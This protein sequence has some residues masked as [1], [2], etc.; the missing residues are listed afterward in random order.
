RNNVDDMFDDLKKDLHKRMDT[1]ARPREEKKPLEMARPACAETKTRIYSFA[2]L[3]DF[4]RFAAQNGKTW[5]IDNSLRK[6]EN[7]R[8]LLFVSRNRASEEKYKAF[9]LR[10]L[11]FAEADH[12]TTQV[13]LDELLEHSRPF[14]EGNAVNK[15]RKYL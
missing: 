11:D 6:A 5:G 3:G 10:L 1:A 13:H 9:R 15:V 14:L 4:E 8:Y 2:T 7:G 12:N